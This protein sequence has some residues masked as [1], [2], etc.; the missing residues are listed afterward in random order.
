MDIYVY[1]RVILQFLAYKNL[2]PPETNIVIKAITFFKFNDKKMFT[3][4]F[5]GVQRFY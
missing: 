3:K 5:K 1:L 2:I 4:Y